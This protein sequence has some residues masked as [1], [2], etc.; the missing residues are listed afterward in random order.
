MQLFYLVLCFCRAVEEW[1]NWT[2]PS[3]PILKKKASQCKKNL[4]WT[5]FYFDFFSN[6]LLHWLKSGA[7]NLYSTSP[8]CWI[9]LADAVE[10]GSWFLVL[11]SWF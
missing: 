11:G 10:A 1:R 8:I 7:S 5:G 4:H 9:G 2:N 6:G 3:Q